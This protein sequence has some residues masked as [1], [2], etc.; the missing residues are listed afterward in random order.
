MAQTT[1]EY[2]GCVGFAKRISHILLSASSQTINSTKMVVFRLVTLCFL[3]Y[4]DVSEEAA[5]SIIIYL[6]IAAIVSSGT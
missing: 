6:S 2:I 3:V 5:T 1:S 4:A